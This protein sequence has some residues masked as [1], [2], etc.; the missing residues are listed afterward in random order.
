MPVGYKMNPKNLFLYA[1]DNIYPVNLLQ[2]TISIIFGEIQTN[3]RV[4]FKIRNTYYPLEVEKS[5]ERLKIGF[6]LSLEYKYGKNTL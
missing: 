2:L 4:F 6:M 3:F 5:L 1:I